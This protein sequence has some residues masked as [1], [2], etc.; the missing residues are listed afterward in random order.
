LFKGFVFL[1]FLWILR[2]PFEVSKSRLGL[3][4]SYGRLLGIC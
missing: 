1:L 4:I 2:I 3:N